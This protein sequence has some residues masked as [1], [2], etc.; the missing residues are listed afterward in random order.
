[1]GGMNRYLSLS[2][3]GIV[4]PFLSS[5]S[6]KQQEWTPVSN[7]P[8]TRSPGIYIYR[9][10]G[11]YYEDHDWESAPPAYN[12]QKW[13]ILERKAVGSELA[14]EIKSILDDEESFEDT[15][16][17]P[18]CFYPGIGIAIDEGGHS[19]EVIT[20]LMCR[21]SMFYEDG[22]S[23]KNITVTNRGRQRFIS[24]YEKAFPDQPKLNVP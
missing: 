2:L 17:A 4:L 5:C 13:P 3:V 8:E 12:L 9:L 16:M 24:L 10:K 21:Y 11:D 22:V 7:A 20:C 15:G 18:G 23:S 1:M 19:T 6:S 14:D